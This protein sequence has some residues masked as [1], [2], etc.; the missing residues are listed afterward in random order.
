ME[1]YCFKKGLKKADVVLTYNDDVVFLSGT[2][3]GL[4]MTDIGV[5]NMSKCTSYKVNENHDIR[6]NTY[7][8]I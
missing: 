6:S 4:G 7:I 2:P 8:Y 1:S 5:Y 3:A